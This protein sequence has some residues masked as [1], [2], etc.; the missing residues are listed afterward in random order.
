MDTSAK[1]YIKAVV[2]ILIALA[3]LLLVILLLPKVIVFFMPFVIGWIIACIASPPVRFFE[4][5]MKIRRK[6]GSAFVIIVVIGLVVLCMYLVGGK[7]IRESISFVND[8][9]E[10]WE[11]LEKELDDIANNLSVVLQKLPVD[12]Q[13]MW[14]NIEQQT[15]AFV[16]EMVSRAGS[17]TIAAVGNFAKSLPPIIIGVIMCLLSSYLFVAER[18]TVSETVARIMPE[19]LLYRWRMIKRVTVKAVGGYFK[20]QI[21][22]EIW[23]YL[24]LVIGLLILKVNYVFP[25]AL[26]IAFLDFLPFFG[27]GTI[28]V[29]WAI[30][31][32]LSADYKMTIG[33][34]I[35][36]GVGQLVRQLIQPKIM[37]D[38]MGMPPLP[39]LFL[40][41]IGYRVGGVVGMIIAIPIGIIVVELYKGGAFETT[42]NSIRILTAG[43]NRFR[44]LT[45]QDLAVIRSYQQ[46][47]EQDRIER[48]KR[49]REK[50]EREKREQEKRNEK[51]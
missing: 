10:M 36:W 32:F 41:Y 51:L 27:T 45:D 7:L 13:D 39:T 21:R 24:L 23:I 5:K 3:G 29:P 6:A 49:E 43:L 17:P 18:K 16:M 48:E 12:V 22:I 33:L 26:V 44:R 50:R 4:E 37:G 15:S 31:K 8:L 20:A 35:I 40:L 47:C 14:N 11:G 1:K 30:I 42:Q 9:P 34:L 46:E 38:S 19:S 25:V 28:M 2:N